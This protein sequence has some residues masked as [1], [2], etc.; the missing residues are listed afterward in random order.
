MRT[1]FS[2]HLFKVIRSLNK[3]SIKIDR[4][5]NLLLFIFKLIFVTKVT[6]INLDILI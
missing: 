6:W 2:R 5:L 3:I 1:Y 4:L